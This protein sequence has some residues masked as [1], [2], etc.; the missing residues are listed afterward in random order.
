MRKNLVLLILI[1]IFSLPG[2]AA[3]LF[4]S[5]PEWLKAATTNKGTLLTPPEL[6]SEL[7]A[8][9]KWRLILWQNDNCQKD[10]LVQLDKLARIRLALGRRLYEV[11]E[12]LLMP[13]DKS[14]KVD[15][16][17]KMLQEQ[18]IRVLQLN[19]KQARPILAEETQ[20]FIASPDNYLVLKYPLQAKSEAIYQD[21]K[22]LLNN[23]AS[24]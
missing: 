6:V 19:G 2:A 9:S 10:C 24:K 5:H 12:V 4:Y 20:F 8:R 18:D 17:E 13:S 7:G 14:I 21:I 23:P 1:I 11:D 16:A 22:K 3:W 15:A